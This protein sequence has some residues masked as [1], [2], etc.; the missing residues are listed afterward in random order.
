MST[1]KKRA[2][3]LAYGF[4]GLAACGSRGPLDDSPAPDAFDASLSADVTGSD[5]RSSSD[6]TP[7]IADAGGPDTAGNPIAC[8]QCIGQSCSMQVT[9]CLQSVN[10]RNVLQCAAQ[11]CLSGGTF[12]PQCLIGCAGNDVKAIQDAFAVVQCITG[13]CGNQCLSLLGGLGK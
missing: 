2:W 1:S 10:C 9:A 4:V 6:A 11:K 8:A 3:V 7:P 13:K 12:D 5:A